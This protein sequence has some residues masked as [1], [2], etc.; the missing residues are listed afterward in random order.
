MIRL[1]AGW[2]R[3]ARWWSPRRLSG[4][5]VVGMGLAAGCATRTAAPSAAPAARASAPPRE[6]SLREDADPE[7]MALEDRRAFDAGVLQA[8]MRSTNAPVRARAAMAL[9]RIGDARAVGLLANLLE[10]P[11]SEVREAAAFA[12]GILGEPAL[13]S[14][15]ARLLA[16]PDSRIVSRAAWAIGA[17]ESAGAVSILAAAIPSASS[18]EQRAPM[19]RALWHFST[20]PAADAALPYATDPD[21]RVR[22]AALY[23]LARQPQESSFPTLTAALT[24]PDAATAALCARALGI[25]GKPESIRPLAGAIDAS[26]GAPGISAMGALAAVLQKNP[27][28]PLPTASA[29]R[30]LA[31]AGDADP[32]LAVPALRLLR[33]LTADREVF[34]RLWSV[35][36]T[37]RQ[38]RRDV[39]LQSLMAGLSAGAESLVDSAI[40]SPD[41]F[42]RAA[43]AETLS[44]LPEADAAPRREK[45]A[46]DPDVI[47][48]VKVLEGLE[49]ADAVRSSR[50]LVDASLADS[51]AGVRAA[52][53][54]A[55]GRLEDPANLAILTA[56]VEKSFGDREPDV[57]IAAMGVAEKTPE[58]TQARA[59]L[60]AAYRHPSTLVSRLARRS[61]IKVFH[62]DAATFP[63]REYVTGK[64]PAAYRAIAQQAREHWT[65]LVETERGAFAVR[66]AGDEAPMTVD[67][68]LRLARRSYFDG[69]RIHRV[70]P[71]FV[72]QD[73]DPSGTGNGGPGY[74]IRDELNALPY[75]MGTVGMALAGPDTGGSQWFVTQAPQ[76]H[77]DGRYTVFGQ[78]VAGM[79]V[80]NGV[81]QGDRILRVTLAREGA[82]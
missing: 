58:R 28:E 71:G 25:L 59:V 52:A 77:L 51:D 47:V 55:L 78:V 16:D 41:A 1:V 29:P 61:L 26:R 10:D 80:V 44:S 38:R 2:Q 19:L 53:I 46:A 50:P 76:P 73:G 56:A 48:R 15:L 37:G 12:A 34:R 40:D 42:L 22:S 69:V 31:L 79:D 64:D 17:L 6:F 68:F 45:L 57:P 82:P 13:S 54:E 66:L 49:T 39:A 8:A 60:E 4:A 67:S 43:V 63:S 24:D 81:E 18:A 62:A 11:S 9:G 74:E 30:L 32:N 5:L 70:V 7:L 21:A 23:A 35:A 20:A 75:G 33:W 14:R 36:S 27:R 3:V 65:A 72:V